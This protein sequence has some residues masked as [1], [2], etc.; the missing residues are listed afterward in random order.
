LPFTG[1]V[2][3][4]RVEVVPD[5]PRD[6]SVV[7]LLGRWDAGSVGCWLVVGAGLDSAR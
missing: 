5:P 6:L 2:C 7:V 1:T 4:P 3:C